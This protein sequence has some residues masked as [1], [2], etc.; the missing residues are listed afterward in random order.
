MTRMHF[1]P[2]LDTKVIEDIIWNPKELTPGLQNQ[3]TWVIE[4][5][6]ANKILSS[7]GKKKWK[8]DS[9]DE[10]LWNGK[11]HKLTL[12]SVAD[13]QSCEST[14]AQSR[15]LEHLEVETHE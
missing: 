7:H 10:Q 4:E 1:V 11:S 9:Y 14:A 13:K 8:R 12:Y 5:H 2:D 3:A 6:A 15:N